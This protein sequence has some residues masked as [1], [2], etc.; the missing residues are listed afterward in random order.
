MT[1]EPRWLS[2]QT[3]LLPTKKVWHL[4]V[5]LQGLRD[6]ALLD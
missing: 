4:L 1:G 6:E 3:M 2:K 5:V